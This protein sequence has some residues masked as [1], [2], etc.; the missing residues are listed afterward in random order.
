MPAE[1]R[2]EWIKAARK[3]AEKVGAAMEASESALTLNLPKNMQDETD[4]GFMD[5]LKEGRH[6]NRRFL[7][8]AL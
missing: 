2:P 6:L 5:Y 8:N 3:A 7:E 1:P 4:R